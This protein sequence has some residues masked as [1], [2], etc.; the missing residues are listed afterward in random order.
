MSQE[1]VS[2]SETVVQNQLETPKST[3]AEFNLP[4]GYLDGNGVLHSEIHLRE[5]T[6][7]E[8]DLL[9]SNKLSPQKKINMLVSNCLERI[10]TITDKSQF[11]L[12]VPQLPIGDR[13]YLLLALRRTSLGDDYPVEETCPSCSVSGRYV[14][15]LGDLDI[16]R[17]PDP[18]RRVF[19]T[20][21]PSG[22]TVRFRIGN[23]LDEERLAKVSDEDKP[24][25]MLL[26][27]TELLNGKA[28]TMA[29]IKT[30]SWRDRQALREAFDENDGGVETGMDLM[31]PACGH[32]FNKD[33]DMG[34]QGF[35]FP[36]RALKDSKKK[37]SI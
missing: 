21:L 9:A 15:N 12:I 1:K 34:Q 3:H 36:Q 20:T 2:F 24:S 4:C 17:M 7:R 35:F 13:V 28:P 10:G 11:P 27:R 26:S 19:D 30:L 5:M 31:C 18:T 29:D 22:K 25:T 14:L 6:G 37:S 32:E 33:L 8:E 23:G 16:K